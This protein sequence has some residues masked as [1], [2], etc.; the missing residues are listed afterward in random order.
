MLRCQ[1]SLLIYT[2]L[3]WFLCFA[4][5]GAGLRSAQHSPAHEALE[6]KEEWGWGEKQNW[7]RN[8]GK[9]GMMKPMLTSREKG[10]GEFGSV[11][12]LEI[13][14]A[15][16]CFSY[17]FCLLDVLWDAQA[18]LCVGSMLQTMVQMLMLAHEPWVEEESRLGKWRLLLL[19]TSLFACIPGF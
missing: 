15:V 19:V 18:V 17:L 8:R 13:K 2:H 14:D 7:L 11:R 16:W 4:G 1:Q 9:K 6:V 5:R 10:V 12:L 3:F